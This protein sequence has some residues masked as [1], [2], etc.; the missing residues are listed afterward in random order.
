M[1]VRCFVAVDFEDP[2]LLDSLV[3]AQDLLRGTGA[4]LKVVERE[5]I[6]LTMRFL[7]D[8]REGL[9][10]ELKGVVSGIG[11]EPFR[12]ELRGLGAFPNLRRPRVVWVGLTKGAEELSEIFKR[13]ES[14]LLGLGFRPEGRGFSPHITLARV[15][16]GR[17]RE[18]LAEQVSR[19]ADEEFG[20]F[21]VRYIRLKKSVLTPKGSIYSTIAQS[22]T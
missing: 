21:T 13:L 9:L 7:G 11:F 2:E 20:E 16:S 4:D 22:G 15:R 3:R 14:G 18:K 5:N 17:N 12:A 19:N 6:H 10:E 1:G 8:V